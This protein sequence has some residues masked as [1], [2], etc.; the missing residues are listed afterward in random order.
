[1]LHSYKPSS[2]SSS[3]CTSNVS[4]TVKTEYFLKKDVQKV[5]LDFL[6]LGSNYLFNYMAPFFALSI[7]G[8]A[9]FS[10]WNN[11]QTLLKPG[12]LITTSTSPEWKTPQPGSKQKNVMP[13]YNKLQDFKQK[14]Y[15]LPVQFF[16]FLPFCSNNKSC[17]DQ[18]P[19]G[20]LPSDLNERLW[21]GHTKRCGF[22]LVISP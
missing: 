12:Q 21:K 14:L 4:S 13:Y 8:K 7:A 18:I 15:F 5:C 2:A 20:P 6:L 11:L 17:V 16:L 1:M 22:V 9:F 3:L 19:A 10:R